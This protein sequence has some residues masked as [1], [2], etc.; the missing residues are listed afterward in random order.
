MLERAAADGQAAHTIG[1]H[2]LVSLQLAPVMTAAEIFL[3]SVLLF[4]IVVL[5]W[6]RWHGEQ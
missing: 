2:S 3:A 6:T 5:I 1:Y 4:L